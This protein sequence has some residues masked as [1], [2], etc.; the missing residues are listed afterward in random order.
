MYWLIA[1]GVL[2][3]VVAIWAALVRPWM[4]TQWWASD[5]LGAIEPFERF[6][7]LKSESVLWARLKQFVGVVLTALTQLGAVDITPLL[8][9]I[10]DV[11]DE[12]VIIGWNMLPMIIAAVG[13]IDE[14]MRTEDTTK[15]IELVSV[16]NRVLEDNPDVVEKMFIA[17]N[18][19][20]DAV[21]AVIA[22]RVV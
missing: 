9:I 1:L 6:A 13:W 14:R 4:R 2:T 21:R 5:F 16:S 20:I 19:K 17:E 7:Y 12:Y 8:P 11:Y 10:P 22:T 18:A 3:I 15:P